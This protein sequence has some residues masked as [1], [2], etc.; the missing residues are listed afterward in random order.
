[1]I[2]KYF[3][4][5]QFKKFITQFSA[6]FSNLQVKTG[7]R[8]DGTIEVLDV[9]VRYG[10]ID[11]V[12]ASIKNANTQNKVLALP[13]M[14]TYLLGIDLA[15]QRRK[16]VGHVDR[17]TF[18]PAGGV[19]PDDLQVMERVMPIPYDLTF[20]LAIYA[21]NSDQMFQILEQLLIVFD[22]TLQIQV[23]DSEFDWTRN[24]N[25]ELTGLAP[26][27]NYPIGADRRIIVWNLNFRMEVWIT[28]PM[29]VRSELIKKIVIRFGDTD[30]FVLNE[31]DANGELMP[32]SGEVWDQMVLEPNHI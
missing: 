15:P 25:V 23:N 27:E 14:S 32:F 7:K 18:M 28:P 4:D 11:R 3:Y 16:G 5:E 19:F 12:V 26:E 13:I 21:S 24:C 8:E 2:S 29:D 17:K 6:I 22:P 20:E 30:S 1:M 9:P 31:Y 10:S